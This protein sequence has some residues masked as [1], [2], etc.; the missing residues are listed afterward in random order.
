[1]Q[2][3]FVSG[4]G[5]VVFCPCLKKQSS[6]AREE[7]MYATSQGRL[8]TAQQFRPLLYHP[9][10]QRPQDQQLSRQTAGIIP[11]RL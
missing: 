4:I 7:V 1:M 9:F 6:A 2:I 3:R 11:E 5:A 8:R 10:I